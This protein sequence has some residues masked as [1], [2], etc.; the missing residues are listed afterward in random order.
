[1]AEP[2]KTSSSDLGIRILLTGIFPKPVWRPSENGDHF[3]DHTWHFMIAAG[4]RCLIGPAE[5][6]D[7]KLENLPG[8][9]CEVLDGAHKGIRFS[10]SLAQFELMSG[11]AADAQLARDLIGGGGK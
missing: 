11:Q 6:R 8:Q 3:L 5:F 1:M 7:A 10:I 4:T 9:L 2:D